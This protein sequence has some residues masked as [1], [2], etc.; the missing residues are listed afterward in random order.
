MKMINISNTKIL[1]LAENRAGITLFG[2][3][4]LYSIKVQETKIVALSWSILKC[5]STLLHNQEAQETVISSADS[6]P[7]T[8]RIR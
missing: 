3:R 4:Y 8:L 7:S 6:A 1:F 2:R 5:I